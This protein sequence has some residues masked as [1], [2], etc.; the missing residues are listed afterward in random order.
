MSVEETIRTEGRKMRRTFVVTIV[1]VCL[2]VVAAQ[3]T[4]LA[5][6]KYLALKNTAK[7]A[8]AKGLELQAAT[9]QAFNNAAAQLKAINQKIAAAE[10]KLARSEKSGKSVSDKVSKLEKT[11]K[12]LEK[13]APTTDE[14]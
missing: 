14:S 6:G 13:K 4:P 3:L 8:K 5:M 12:D 7:Q 10:G 9:T 11:V 1:G 2:A